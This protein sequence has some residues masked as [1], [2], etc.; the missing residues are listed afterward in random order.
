M[1]RLIEHI[2]GW[3]QRRRDQA[4]ETESR[5]N[6]VIT[7]SGS[8]IPGHRITV[9]GT[10]QY[11]DSWSPTHTRRQVKLQAHALGANYIINYREEQAG[12][13]DGIKCTGDAVLAQAN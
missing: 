2:T 7:F 3:T 10:V 1:K 5:A 6:S 13:G 12:G 9:L 4:A 8:D 11:R